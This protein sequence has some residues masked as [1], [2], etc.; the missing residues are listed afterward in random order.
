VSDTEQPPRI[1]VPAGAVVLRNEFA[2]IAVALD[3]QGK[4]PRLRIVDLR[5]GVES[6]LDPLELEAL[7]WAWHEDLAPLLDPSHRRW[8]D[9]AD[10]DEDED[11]NAN[12]DG[13]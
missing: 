12:G 6:L 13:R 5:S 3:H 9:P 7:A 10:E 4:H 8:R 1:P 11:E 2:H